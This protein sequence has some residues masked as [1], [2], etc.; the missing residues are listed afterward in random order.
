[1]PN[2][3]FSSFIAIVS[4]FFSSLSRRICLTMIEDPLAAATANLALGQSSET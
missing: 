4:I 1:M 3:S 2:P